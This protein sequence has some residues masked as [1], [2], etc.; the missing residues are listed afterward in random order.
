M[1]RIILMG[2]LLAIP[3]HVRAQNR[4]DSPEPAH[5]A[6]YTELFGTAQVPPPLGASWNLEIKVLPHT[7][8]RAG[9]GAALIADQA[10]S[11]SL[12][13]IEWLV[14]LSRAWA[15][16]AGA[17]VLH[18]DEGTVAK[19]YSTGGTYLIGIRK[20]RRDEVG[21]LTFTPITA[22]FSAKWQRRRRFIP[23]IGASLGIT[24]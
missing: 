11:A 6:A 1:K 8:V 3:G 4:T 13:M 7:F 10:N 17:G 24:F 14:P 9:F 21:R 2:L 19:T 23:A 20:Q 18:S 5:G 12:A 15:L 16:E 22:P